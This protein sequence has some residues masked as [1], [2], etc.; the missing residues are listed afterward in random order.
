MAKIPDLRAVDP[1]R[2]GVNVDT[3]AIPDLIDSLK[4][5]NEAWML[6][7]NSGDTAHLDEFVQEARKGEA[8]Y[9]CMKYRG[10]DIRASLRMDRLTAIEQK[11]EDANKKK[12]ALL[13]RTLSDESNIWA[14]VQMAEGQEW[15]E[16]RVERLKRRIQNRRNW[17]DRYAEAPKSI[18]RHGA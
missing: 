8:L 4:A 7:S 13:A 15:L 16:R 14:E 11:L 9:R 12:A 2:T 6:F 18:N 3:V 1:L 10:T 17:L 5:L